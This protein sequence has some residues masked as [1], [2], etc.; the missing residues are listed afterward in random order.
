M[1]R[2]KPQK[3]I[4]APDAVYSDKTVSKFI[5]RLMIKGKKAVAEGVFYQALDLLEG[6]AE[7]KPIEVFH[8]VLKKVAPRVKVKARRVGGATYQVPMEV[9]EDD[10]EALGSRWLIAAARKRAGRSMSEKLAYEMQD[11]LKGLGAAMKK[12]EE[13]HRMAEANR[14]FAHFRF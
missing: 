12:R 14:A 3:R 2:T 10:G 7:G 1:R 9:T 5:N 6:K 11:V 4:P 8:Q 13:T